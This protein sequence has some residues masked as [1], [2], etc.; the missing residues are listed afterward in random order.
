MWLSGA[1]V[2]LP[3]GV[4]SQAS[5]RLEEGR[6]AEVRMGR[7]AG[8]LPLEGFTVVPGVV[9]L[10]GDTLERE[11]EP[12]PG[13]YLPLEM[14][15]EA[16]EAR[17]LGAGITTA[18]VAMSFWEGAAGVRAVEK[19]LEIVRG[20][21]FLR[22]ALSLDLRIHVRYEVSRPQGEWAV[23]AALEE[24]LVHLLSLMDHTPGQGQFRD[25]ETYVAYMSRWLGRSPEEVAQDLVPTRVAWAA[26][27]ELVREARA[28]GV[29]LAS[30]DDD[31]P[32]RVALMA[33][34]GVEIS[35][36][37][38]TL[39]AAR[40]AWSSGLWLVMGAPNALRGGSHNGNLSALEAL[41]HGFLHA[42]ATDYHPGSA[43]RAAFALAERG[44][45]PLEKGVALVSLFPARAVGLKDRGALLPGLRG[46][47][48]VLE[49]KPFA[50]VGVFVGGKPVLLRGRF[51]EVWG[52]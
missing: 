21:R 27:E 2:V 28:R 18:Y 12:R 31:T 45:L 26:L 49:E 7:V 34:L 51:A 44:L 42:L 14:A 17:L 36:F 40:A 25:F 16:W 50:V 38:L 6:V 24:G 1:K 3:E 19:S 8:G 30:H 33:R 23:R 15:L 47:L 4:L 5:L 29:V 41:Q 10:H 43:L 48:V 35:E 46:D 20:L 32:E 39:A 11:L 13:V 22:G 52:G 9:D 37:P